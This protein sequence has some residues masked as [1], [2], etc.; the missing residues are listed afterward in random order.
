VVTLYFP[1]S[2][3]AGGVPTTPT[4][5]PPM[6]FLSSTAA[7]EGRAHPGTHLPPSSLQPLSSPVVESPSDDEFDSDPMLSSPHINRPQS[8]PVFG[9]QAKPGAGPRNGKGG[10]SLTPQATTKKSRRPTAKV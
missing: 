9:H 4:F 6:K 2:T 1:E 8:A 7:N 3:A 5:L 10:R